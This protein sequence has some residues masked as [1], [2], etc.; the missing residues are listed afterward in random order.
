ME[1][2]QITFLRYAGS[3]RRLLSYIKEYLQPPNLIPGKYKLQNKD[4]CKT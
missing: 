2:V 1:N 3:K 4:S